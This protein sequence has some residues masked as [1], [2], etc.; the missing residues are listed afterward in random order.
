M[1]FRTRKARIAALTLAVATAALVAATAFAGVTVYKNN[2][3]SKREAKEL[4][5]AEGKKCEKNWRKKGE[6]IAVKARKGPMVCGYRPPVEGDGAA[7]DH[8]IQV[9]EKLLKDTPKSVRDRAYLGVAVRSGKKG[10]YELWVFPT[11][12]KFK[13]ARRAGKGP[14]TFLAK[15]NNKAIKGPDKSNVMSLKA[16]GSKLI[17]KVNGK[18]VAKAVDRNASGIKGRKLEAMLGNKKRRNKAAVATFDNVKVQV[19]KP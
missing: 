5:H 9:Q 10:G 16:V 6:S 17:A 1:G 2:F 13:L 3:S 14:P 12:Q 15:G 19:P 11:K 4:R 7:P 18:R 8:S